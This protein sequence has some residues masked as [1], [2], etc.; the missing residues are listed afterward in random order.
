MSA[1]RKSENDKGRYLSPFY[2]RNNDSPYNGGN[3]NRQPSGN[4]GL[5]AKGSAATRKSGGL[6]EADILQRLISC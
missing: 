2:N 1:G 3:L 6:S 5:S 4:S